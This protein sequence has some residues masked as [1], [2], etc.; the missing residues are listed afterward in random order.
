[1]I[2]LLHIFWA[3]VLT[4]AVLVWAADAQP[5]DILLPKQNIGLTWVIGLGVLVLTLIAG[6]K[7]PGRTHLD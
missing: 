6:F 3:F 2:R 7:H 1:M 5:T 4:P